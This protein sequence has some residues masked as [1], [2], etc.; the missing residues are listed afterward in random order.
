M[1]RQLRDRPDDWYEQARRE[2][3]IMELLDQMG[4]MTVG[5]IARQTGLERQ[6]VVMML[7]GLR[8]AECVGVDRKT[9][10][11]YLLPPPTA[12]GVSTMSQQLALELG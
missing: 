3:K 12:E 11:F 9:G 2:L 1:I 10:I 5:A 8:L 4:P 7:Y 6:Q